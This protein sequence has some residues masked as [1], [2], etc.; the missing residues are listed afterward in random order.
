MQ[1]PLQISFDGSPASA[2]V[3]SVCRA[4]VEKLERYSHRITGCRVVISAASH[5]HVKGTLYEVRIALTLPLRKMIVVTRVP[6]RHASN[7]VIELAVREAF[8]TARRRIEDAVRKQRGSIKEH[9]TPAHGQVARTFPLERYGFIETPD[10]REL[11][12]HANSLLGSAFDDL[13]VG[14]P[15]RFV[16]EPAAQGSQ[17][18]SVALVG[19][20]HHLA[21]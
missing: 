17:A 6:P 8:D 14:Q 19:K 15:V 7:E 11:Y 18:T 4:E 12:F 21:P 5:R 3:E 2:H 13:E 1:I 9:D 10:G 16:E 20:H